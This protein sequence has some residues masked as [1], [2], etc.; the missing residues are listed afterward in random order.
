VDAIEMTTT[1]TLSCLGMFAFAIGGLALLFYFLY[2]NK[3]GAAAV[4]AACLVLGTCAVV[5]RPPRQ[6]DARAPEP[7]TA[8]PSPSVSSPSPEQLT[9][10]PPAPRDATLDSATSTVSPTATVSP[11][12][13]ET[14]GVEADRDVKTSTAESAARRR[15]I[16][17]LLLDPST[18]LFHEPTCPAARGLSTK[19]SP[20]VARM[21]GY[22]PHDCVKS[23]STGE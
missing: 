6:Q 1:T 16:A 4:T 13:T 9:T 10:S 21:Q 7:A 11:R 22:R 17:R 2:Q 12:E 20:S 3:L 8:T 18:K 19:A 15:A 14:Q 23:E 5:I